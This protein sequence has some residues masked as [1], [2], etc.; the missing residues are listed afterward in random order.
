VSG[1]MDGHQWLR[2]RRRH[3]EQALDDNPT[4]EER[5]VIE[6]ELERVRAELRRSGGW[7]QWLLWGA[8]RPGP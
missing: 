6:A 7:R 3:L 4:P 1:V 8:R 5:A 2:Q